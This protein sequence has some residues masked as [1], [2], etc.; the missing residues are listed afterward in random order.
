MHAEQLL[1]HRRILDLRIR[2]GSGDLRRGSLQS[3]AGNG[4]NASEF[5]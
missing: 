1:R 3:K 5:F 2:P 4:E